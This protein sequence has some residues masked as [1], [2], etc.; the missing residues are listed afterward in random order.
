MSSESRSSAAYGIGGEETTRMFIG[1]IPFSDGPN[2]TF[3]VTLL[4]PRAS[5]LDTFAD[6]AQPIIDSLVVPDT[7]LSN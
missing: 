2:H 1:T 7:Y 6:A 5:D 3:Y 4:V